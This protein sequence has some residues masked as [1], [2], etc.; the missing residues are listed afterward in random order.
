MREAFD[1]VADG[2]VQDVRTVIAYPPFVFGPATE[3]AVRQ[4]TYLPPTLNGSTL[5]CTGQTLN[6]RFLIPDK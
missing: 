4:F 3:K 2:S 6:V 1:I 5:G